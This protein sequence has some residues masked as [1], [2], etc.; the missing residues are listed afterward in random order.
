MKNRKGKE[1]GPF[2]TFFF[3]DFTDSWSVKDIFFEFKDLGVIDEIFIPAKKDRRGQ[4][5]GFVRFVD[6][7]DE[8]MVERKLNNI[9]LDERKINVNI[10][11]I[12]AW[13][14]EERCRWRTMEWQGR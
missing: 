8:K 11:N 14:Y 9:W 2:T 6:V 4:K 10:P 3:S 12:K 13:C 1:F 5:Y 7:A